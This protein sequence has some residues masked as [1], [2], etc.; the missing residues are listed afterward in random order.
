VNQA[1]RVGVFEHELG[2]QLPPPDWA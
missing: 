2:H 1:L